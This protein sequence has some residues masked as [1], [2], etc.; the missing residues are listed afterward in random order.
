M[1]YPPS[2]GMGVSPP[3]ARRGYPP[4]CEQTEHMTFRHPSDAGGEYIV[5]A[6]KGNKENRMRYATIVSKVSET[7]WTHSSMTWTVLPTS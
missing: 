4:G 2:E 7:Q 6:L 1:G 5:A 3:L